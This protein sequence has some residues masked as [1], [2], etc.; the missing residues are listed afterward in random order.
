MRV[1]E[2]MSPALRKV[3]PARERGAAGGVGVDSIVCE[4]MWFSTL[5]EGYR[6][7]GVDKLNTGPCNVLLGVCDEQY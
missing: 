6:K 7:G 2:S 1:S 4:T 5:L 3:V